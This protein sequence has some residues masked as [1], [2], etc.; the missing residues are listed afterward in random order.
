MCWCKENIV[1]QEYG[2]QV[3][4]LPPFSNGF[5]CIDRCLLNEISLLW[6]LDIVTTGC[7][8]GHNVAQPFIGV[9]IEYIGQMKSLGYNVQ[10]N[11]SRPGDEDSFYPKTINY[12]QSS[13]IDQMG[14]VLKQSLSSNTMRVTFDN[15]ND[16]MNYIL[17]VVDAFKKEWIKYLSC[18]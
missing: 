1:P 18:H 8:C 7:C 4:V 5:I 16:E 6:S 12:K 3:I 9:G 10:P 13:L 17:D 11:K 14:A 2:N 15:K